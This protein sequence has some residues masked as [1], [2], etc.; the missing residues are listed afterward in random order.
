M[1]KPKQITM[2][3]LV[4]HLFLMLVF[5]AHSQ[6]IKG[7]YL[8]GMDVKNGKLSFTKDKNSTTKIKLHDFFYK[9]YITVKNRD[10]TFKILKD[11]LFGY[12]DIDNNIY[13]FYEGKN[14]RLLNPKEE[15]LL[16]SYETKTLEIKYTKTVLN[17]YFSKNYNSP[18]IPLTIANLMEQYRNNNEFIEYLH[19]YYKSDT[20]LCEYDYQHNQYKLNQL[21]QLSNKNKTK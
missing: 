1:P 18:L 15:I 4:S 16:Y 21:L 10:S 17:Y 3:Y 20:E 19:L 7:I 5:Y 11:L 2:K 6:N 9:P 8:S 13:H 12:E 14:Y